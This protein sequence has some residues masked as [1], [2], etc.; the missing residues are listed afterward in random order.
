MVNSQTVRLDLRFGAKQNFR[1][2]QHVS[3]LYES[4]VHVFCEVCGIIRDSTEAMHG[5]TSV[6]HDV[7]HP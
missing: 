6:K 3:Y 4:N 7:D 2:I 1:G 5:L